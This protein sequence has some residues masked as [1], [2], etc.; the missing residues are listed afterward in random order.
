MAVLQDK[1]AIV[2][3]AGT[4]LGQSAAVHFARQGAKVVGCGRTQATLDETAKLVAE[5]GGS[6]TMVAGDVSDATDVARIVA[7]AIEAYGRVDI[8]VNNAAILFSSRE[9]KA[10]SMGTLL[11][12]GEDDWDEVVRVNLRSAFLMCRK[13]VPLMREQGGGAI[14]N[15]SS[16]AAYQGFP[17]SHHY[18]ATKGGLAAFTKSLAVSYGAYNIRVNT[19]IT[20]GFLSPGVADLLPLFEPI[21]G[22]PMMRYLWC[23]L[24]RLAASDELAKTMAFLCSDD[25]SYIHGADVTVDGGLSVNAVPN[26]GPRPPSPPLYVEDLLAAATAECGL[27]DFGDRSFVEGLTAF[28]DALRAEAGLNRMGFMMSG[29]D[30]VRLLVNRLRYVRDLTRHP[31]I[32][33]ERIVAPIVIAGLP[34]TGT[35]KLQR[36]LSADPDVQRLDFWRLLN[37]APFP[38]EQAGDPAARIGTAAAIE[39]ILATQFPDFMAAHPTEALEPDEELLLMEMTFASVVSSMRARVPSFR[40]FVEQRGTDEVYAWTVQML[41]YLQWQDG[42]GRD[43]PWILKSPVH[44]GSFPALLSTFPDATVVACHRDPKVVIPSF[45]RL[46]EAGRRMGCDDVDPIEVG[47]DTLALWS[48]QLRTNLAD[49]AQIDPARIL[50]VQ[51]Q[52]IR[53]DASAVAAEVYARA[54]RELTPEAAAAFAEYETRRPEGAFGHNEYSLERYGLTEAQIESEFAEYYERFPGVREHA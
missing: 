6:S 54:G 9:A 17:N 7:A 21:L 46:M 3:G 37:P 39:R 45:A 33:D 23:P 36:M 19:M 28:T 8:L 12:I 22:D 26:F 24:G 15:V 27:E 50:D 5:A 43:R 51:Y 2:T 52:R 13:V 4:G 18:S 25:A 32:R 44:L 14:L 42:G 11:E 30:I 35:S 10:G 1:V 20:G 29:G 31:E 49:R 16:V 47:A 53:D 40:A 34:R 41:Q 38:G 48:A